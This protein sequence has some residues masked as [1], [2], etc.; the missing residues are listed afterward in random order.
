MKAIR[1]TLM[2]LFFSAVAAHAQEFTFDDD[3]DPEPELPTFTIETF[4][5]KI[6]LINQPGQSC[7]MQ[8]M[9]PTGPMDLEPMKLAFNALKINW[10]GSAVL[11]MEYMKVTLTSD[12]FPS[13]EQ[14]FIYTGADLGF[15]WQ[16][17][18]GVVVLYPQEEN[19]T[20]APACSFELG[21]ISVK[22]KNDAI[23]GQGR[24]MVYATSTDDDENPISLSSETT[25]EFETIP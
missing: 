23:H 25:F 3:L 5:P 13:G 16:G 11:K 22:N 14:T 8:I 9:N 7:K 4:S 19:Q 21:G 20:T 18:P 12:Q 1:L 2:A 24:I 17:S 15:L 6:F 10:A